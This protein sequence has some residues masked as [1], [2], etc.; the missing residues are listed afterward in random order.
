[1]IVHLKLGLWKILL[2]SRNTA[3]FCSMQDSGYQK[4]KQKVPKLVQEKEKT[5]IKRI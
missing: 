2:K 1:M 5:L 4:Q 3:L